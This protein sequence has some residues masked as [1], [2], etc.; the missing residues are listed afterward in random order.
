MES[1]ADLAKGLK[2][3]VRLLVRTLAKN[4]PVLNAIATFQ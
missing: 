3:K 4:N 1:V 2:E